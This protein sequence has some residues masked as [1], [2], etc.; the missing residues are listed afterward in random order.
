MGDRLI[1]LQKLSVFLVDTLLGI[2]GGLDRNDVFSV[3]FRESHFRFFCD[4]GLITAGGFRKKK[5][6]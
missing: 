2:L 6:E 1:S 3:E 4:K 5:G